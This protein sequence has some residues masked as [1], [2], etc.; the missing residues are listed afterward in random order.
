MTDELYVGKDLEGS[1]HDLIK[2]L[3]SIYP[4]EPSKTRKASVMKDIVMSKI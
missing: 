2:T 1:S 3:S 4:K